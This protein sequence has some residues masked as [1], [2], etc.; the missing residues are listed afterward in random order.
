MRDDGW[1]SIDWRDDGFGRSECRED[2]GFGSIDCRFEAFFTGIIWPRP[3]SGGGGGGGGMMLDRERE[4]V[5]AE[6]TRDRRRF[7]CESGVAGISFLPGV[8]GSPLLLLLKLPPAVERRVE[9]G[10]RTAPPPRRL[11]RRRGE[12]AGGAPASDLVGLL[13]ER[14]LPRPYR[15]RIRRA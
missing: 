4:G 12:A 9:S 13:G 3:S 6:T 14:W 7:A 5:A 15:L 8:G 11:V 2:D 10:W 1:G